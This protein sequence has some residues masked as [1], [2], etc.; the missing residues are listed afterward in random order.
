MTSICHSGGWAKLEV[1]KSQRVLT[2]WLAKHVS[3]NRDGGV[4][5]GGCRD[6]LARKAEE[7]WVVAYTVTVTVL[8]TRCDGKDWCGESCGGSG[9]R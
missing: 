6:G 4:S 9:I 3:V 5:A 7:A 1:G 8:V 2:M